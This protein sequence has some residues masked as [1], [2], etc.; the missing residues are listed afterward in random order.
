MTV[1]QEIRSKTASERK[2]I[3]DARSPEQRLELLNQ[4]F[5]EGLGA[6][7]ERAKIRQLT[8]SKGKKE[9]TVSEALKTTLSP[10]ILAEMD[11]INKPSGKKT[12]QKKE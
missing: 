4:K 11:E 12:K 2:L 5:G 7:K 9:E 8:N 1:N 3:S 6:K 10:E